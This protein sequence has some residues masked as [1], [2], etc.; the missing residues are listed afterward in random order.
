MMSGKEV[1]CLIDTGATL[2]LISLRIW[3]SFSDDVKQMSLA[4]ASGESILMKGKTHKDIKINGLLFD[5]DF[6]IADIE[7]DVILGLDFLKK[8]GG[9][10]DHADNILPLHAH[11]F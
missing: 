3:D 2:S 1:D 10:L 4:S 5:C 11:C 8:E 7:A 6:V 9:A